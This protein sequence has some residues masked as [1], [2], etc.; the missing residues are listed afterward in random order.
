[1]HIPTRALVL[2]Q[3]PHPPDQT[4]VCVIY[5]YHSNW[6]H[7]TRQFSNRALLAPLT[8]ADLE[9]GR[10]PDNDTSDDDTSDDDRSVKSAGSDA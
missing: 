5:T 8:D 7:K 10:R 4:V 2:Y 3:A 9:E 6:R 1:M